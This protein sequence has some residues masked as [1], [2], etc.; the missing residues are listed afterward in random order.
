M[1][2]FD[3]YGWIPNSPSTMRRQ[4]PQ[5]KDQVN[6][7]FIMESLPDRECSREVLGTVWSLTRTEQNEV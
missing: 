3:W 4:P 6:E 7:N 2:Q 1:F 5:L